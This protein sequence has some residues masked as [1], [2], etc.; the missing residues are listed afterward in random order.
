M[1]SYDKPFKF[2][3]IVLKYL[4]VDN[5][6]VFGKMFDHVNRAWENYKSKEKKNIL[7]K[8]KYYILKLM[9]A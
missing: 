2:L 4:K 3:E 7:N 9:F 6:Q 5:R 1:V 8:L